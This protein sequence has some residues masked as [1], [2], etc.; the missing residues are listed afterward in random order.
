M[1]PTYFNASLRI[2]LDDFIGQKI[3]DDVIKRIELIYEKTR[4]PFQTLFWFEDEKLMAKELKRFVD[5]TQN[6]LPFKTTIKSLNN[7]KVYNFAWF[8]LVSNEDKNKVNEILSTSLDCRFKYI[9]QKGDQKQFLNGLEEF[10]NILTFT[11]KPNPK[12][13]KRNDYEEDSHSW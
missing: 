10:N 3:E 7:I 13:Q 12:K 11:L 5:N 4:Y 8:N 6:K 2:K 9:Y 1:H